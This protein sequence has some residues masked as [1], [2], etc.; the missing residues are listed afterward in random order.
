MSSRADSN[1]PNVDPAHHAPRRYSG[2][3]RLITR[4]GYTDGELPTQQT[5]NAKLNMLGYRLAKVAK[6]RPQ[7]GSRRPTPSSSS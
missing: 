2:W 3:S 5:I 6:C 4:K 1:A 7:K